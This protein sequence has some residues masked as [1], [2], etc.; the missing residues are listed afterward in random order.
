MAELLEEATHV[1]ESLK[2]ITLTTLDGTYALG[3][4]LYRRGDRYIVRAHR[5]A[6]PECLDTPRAVVKLSLRTALPSPEERLLYKAKKVAIDAGGDTHW[7]LQHLP[8]IIHN[9]DLRITPGST[10]ARVVK[11]IDNVFC[12]C[13]PCEE[14]V[15]RDEGP[16]TLRIVFME[17][18]FSIKTL[19]TA[20]DLAQVFFDILNCEWSCCR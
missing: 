15:L 12:H 9:E 4:M 5:I 7:V 18:L 19:T 20:S 1:H 10:Q 11:I 3:E 14:R 6:A 13:D 17:E 8:N 16:E 2:G